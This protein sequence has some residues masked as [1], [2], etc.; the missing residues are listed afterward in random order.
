MDTAKY[1][2]LLSYYDDH[3]LP[4][5]EQEEIHN[6]TVD[7]LSQMI[8]DREDSDTYQLEIALADDPQYPSYWWDG[9]ALQEV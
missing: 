3:S 5:G 4:T 8:I 1:D 6:M 9:N 2:W 7:E